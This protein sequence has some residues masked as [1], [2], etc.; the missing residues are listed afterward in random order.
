MKPLKAADLFAGAGGAS[1]GLVQACEALGVPLDLLAIN[2]WPTAVETHAQNHSWARHM[3]ETLD[4]VDPRKLVDGR[5]D[6]LM[7]GPECIHHANAR[8]GRPVNDQSRA[9]A[10]HV[11]RWAEAL[12]PKWI[13]VENIREFLKWGPLGADDKPLKSRRG[14]LFGMWAQT[15]RTLGYTLEWRVLCAADYGAATSR[16][17][18]FVLGRLDGG[19]SRG[20]L[21]WPDQ[22]HASAAAPPLLRHQLER[23]RGAREVIDWSL[24]GR[25]IFRR[26]KPLADATL[27]RIAAGAR[28]F[29]GVDLEPFMVV[30]RKNAD[31]VSL[32]KPLPSITAQGSHFGLVQPF[33]LGQQSGSVARPVQQP[34]PTVATGGALSLIEPFLIAYY[35]SGENADSIRKPLRTVTTRDR[36][37]LVE[38][39][40]V[41]I[42][43]RML[44][45]HE[46]AAGQ[47]FPKGYRFAGS[48][49]EVKA[50]IGNAWEVTKATA[51]CRSIVGAH[52]GREE[53]AA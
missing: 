46:L 14:E 20:P 8:G 33:I 19:R 5:L 25:S 37:G 34:L 43:L 51:L 41:D 12:R 28:K 6:V 36:F 13:L 50:Q 1:T 9:T 32:D 15:L 3:C 17:R 29:W 45:N 18:L 27:K 7:A 24:E 22:T 42:T 38:P 39:S 35:G 30:L 23:W 47:G 4:S 31:A 21:P 26:S 2:H 16:H 40:S 53:R 11:V 44:A 10:W 52:I 48:D 49:G